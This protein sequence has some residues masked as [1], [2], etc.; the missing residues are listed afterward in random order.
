[1]LVKAYEGAL[2]EK[3]RKQGGLNSPIIR[4]ADQYSAQTGSLGL[5]SVDDWDF[6]DKK[7]HNGNRIY[8]FV[9]IEK[10]TSQSLQRGLLFSRNMNILAV[11]AVLTLKT[12]GVKAKGPCALDSLTMAIEKM[13]PTL[14]RLVHG[15]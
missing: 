2:A 14:T 9:E 15:R 7:D 4:G 1:M 13:K 12:D 10:G 6:D 3:I 5:A 11:K 8:I